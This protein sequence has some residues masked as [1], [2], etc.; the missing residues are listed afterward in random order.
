MTEQTPDTENT[1][2]LPRINVEAVLR[3][4]VELSLQDTDQSRE[5]SEEELVSIGR[6]LGLAP[7][8]VRQALCERPGPEGELGVL[9]RHFG[10]ADLV[11]TR[12]VPWNDTRAMRELEDHLVTREY[13]QLRR[14]QGGNAIFEPADDAFSSIARA[15]SR[16]A[17]K[18]HVARA[19]RVYL[20]V[21]PLD[22]ESAHVRMELRYPQQRTSYITTAAI[23]GSSFGVGLGVLA[24]FAIAPLG[25]VAA[26]TGGIASFGAVLASSLAIA[27]NAFRSFITKSRDEAEG[28]L[29]RLEQGERLQPP[30]SPWIRRLQQ[31]LR[32]FR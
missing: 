4:A 13:L 8:H 28:L 24:G 10:R 16:P 9:D 23:I 27:R 25:D 3:R 30:P 31:K 29:D 6:E 21:R 2:G 11:L 20:T 26:V 12:A 1:S 32:D 19:Q 22:A 14:R 15:F 18:Y 7:R 17:S 5:L